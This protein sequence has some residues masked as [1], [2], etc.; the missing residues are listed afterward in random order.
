MNAVAVLGSTGSIGRSTLAVI[1]MHPDRFRVA[2]LGAHRSW[3]AVVEQ[4]RIVRPD[5][6][7]LVD[8]EAAAHAERALRDLRLATRVISGADALCDAVSL[9][10]VHTVMAAIVGAAGLLSTMAA[11]RA[12]KRV[13]LA[14]KESLVMAGRLLMDEVQ[15]AGAELI[16]IDSEHNAIF[17]CM[18]AG[19]LPGIAGRGVTRLILTASG[20]PFRDR[21]L[22]DLAG[23]TPAGA[24]TAAPG[25]PAA[26]PR[27]RPT[28]RTRASRRSRP[29]R[30]RS[31]P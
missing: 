16:P 24:M 7:V 11:A 17:Q 21:T 5:L 27:R 23:V 1:A 2:V 15:R 14:N 20:G 9:P 25:R 10:E 18:P 19:F 26:R 31:S 13:L 22:G 6:V 29:A 4:A 3:Q 30:P 28:W 8:P 12:G